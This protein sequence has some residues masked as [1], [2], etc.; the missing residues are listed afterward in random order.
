MAVLKSFRLLAEE[1]AIRVADEE[2]DRAS[3]IVKGWQ[4]KASYHTVSI[5]IVPGKAKPV[6]NEPFKYTM[7][8]M[9]SRGSK[10]QSRWSEI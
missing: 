2:R 5:E 8:G 6:D 10:R 4:D 3:A 9:R 7:D 1:E